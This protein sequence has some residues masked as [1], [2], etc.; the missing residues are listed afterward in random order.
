MALHQRIQT[1]FFREPRNGRFDWILVGFG[2]SIVVISIAGILVDDAQGTVFSVNPEYVLLGV[3][4]VLMG[5]AE[6][7]PV[8][9][10]RRAAVLRVAT[11]G[12]FLAWWVTLL[13][14]P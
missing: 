2:V 5:G 8:D 4:F 6:L 11:V 10:Q 14:P 1:A 9:Q 3:A 12:A 13:L 7:L